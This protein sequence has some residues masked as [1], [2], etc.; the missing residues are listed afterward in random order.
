MGVAFLPLRLDGRLNSALAVAA[1]LANIARNGYL[2]REP[3]PLR[4]QEAGLA[5]RG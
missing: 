3:R 1:P 2:K 5:R 4:E